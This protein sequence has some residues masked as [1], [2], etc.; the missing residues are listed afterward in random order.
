M[1]NMFV[2]PPRVFDDIRE[3]ATLQ[4]VNQ[5]GNTFLKG[6][7]AQ[8][9][10]E[11]ADDI[12]LQ[13]M[14][15]GNRIQFCMRPG[16]TRGPKTLPHTSTSPRPIGIKTAVILD[17]MAKYLHGCMFWPFGRINWHS[18]VASASKTSSATWLNRQTPHTQ[19]MFLK[20]F[21]DLN[22][23]HEFPTEHEDIVNPT[24][25][26]NAVI[27]KHK[28]FRTPRINVSR[29]RLQDNGSADFAS[30]PRAC[31]ASDASGFSMGIQCQANATRCWVSFGI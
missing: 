10:L 11:I 5:H 3:H 28:P 15:F 1:V 19:N 24:R 30:N 27:S 20:L 29:K 6:P 7:T 17:N 31:E 18:S 12:P 2:F 14:C 8:S 23:V 16:T 4:F 26:A 13:T 25:N 9:P 21:G 22:S